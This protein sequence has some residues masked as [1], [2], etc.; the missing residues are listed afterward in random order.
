MRYAF[1]DLLKRGGLERNALGE[2]YSLYSLRHFYAVRAL[3]RRVDVYM[4]ARNMGTSVQIIQDYY[5]RRVTAEMGGE[6]LGD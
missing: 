5:G 2:R 3:R 4:L 6:Q 1:A